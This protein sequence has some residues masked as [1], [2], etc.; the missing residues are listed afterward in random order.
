[1][2]RSDFIFKNF[3]IE[4]FGFFNST[5]VLFE[6]ELTNLVH[7]I[8]KKQFAVKFPYFLFHLNENRLSYIKVAEH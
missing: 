4:T 6:K 2:L 7:K 1:M 3:E 8:F 5:W